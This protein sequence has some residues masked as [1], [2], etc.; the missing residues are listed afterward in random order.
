[1]MKKFLACLLM[2]TPSFL[3]SAAGLSL[4][5]NPAF[6]SNT[7]SW[8]LPQYKLLGAY[9]YHK[10]DVYRTFGYSAGVDG[11]SLIASG[12]IAGSYTDPV[13][14]GSYSYEIRNV[15]QCNYIATDDTWDFSAAFPDYGP[16]AS[17]FI[18]GEAGTRSV[19]RSDAG[20]GQETYDTEWRFE[21]YL[22]YDCYTDVRIYKPGTKFTLDSEGFYE[23]PA[24]TWCIRKI[25][26]YNDV[27][28]T[29]RSGEMA[30]GSWSETDVWDCTDSSGNLV[31]NGIYYIMIEVFD[32]FDPPAEYEI[33]FS[34]N[35]YVGGIYKKRDA[36]VVTIPVDILRVKDLTAT[37]ITQTNT[38]SLI[39]YSINASADVKVLVLNSG[40][41][42][43]IADSAGSITYGSGSSYNYKP[44]DLIPASTGTFA[45]ADMVQ[46]ITYYRGAG[47]NT[48][49]WDGIGPTGLAVA[50]G[51][52]PIG[53]CARD[54]SGNT[55]VSTDGNDHPFFAYITVDRRTSATAVEGDVPV[56]VSVS[57]SSTT[58]GSCALITVVLEDAS[59]VNAA[60]TTISV[61]SGTTVYSHANANATQSPITGTGAT[62]TLTFS[63][64]IT[65]AGTY[66]I[67][68]VAEDNNGNQHTYTSKFSIVAG[69]GAGDNFKA[70]VKAYPQPAGKSPYPAGS[71]TMR[72]DESGAIFA[73]DNVN[74]TLEVYTIFGEKVK[75]HAATS[76]TGTFPWN[77]SSLGLAPGVYI[78][79]IKAVGNGKTCEAVKK[80]VIYK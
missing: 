5:W 61:T 46:V 59:G 77:Y 41:N 31:G 69:A 67:T 19:K 57:P 42:F 65:G 62:F 26:D 39:S 80:M 73:G 58:I 32:A 3:F 12:V 36:I 30:D 27:E 37:G 51:I 71:I 18:H 49:T 10:V 76:T 29:A 63:T 50:N 34:T 28:S 47:V 72:Y 1:M 8:N 70:I 21:Y 14:Y 40:A 56:L 35:Y 79:R 68:V 75:T 44:G 55:A 45:S 38:A 24:S 25:V 17:Y 20:G 33:G 60:A 16:V 74:L 64:V 4:T 9:Q 22:Q 6:Q 78:Y 7:L 54:A 52:Y 11:W 66:T 15:V 23:K 13:G 43:Q 48:E 2:L 53:I